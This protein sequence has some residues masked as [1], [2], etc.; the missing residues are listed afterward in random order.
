MKSETTM[1]K[2]EHKEDQGHENRGTGTS[3]ARS[4]NVLHISDGSTKIII[5]ATISVVRASDEKKKAEKCFLGQE[6]GEGRTSDKKAIGL[7]SKQTVQTME[8]STRVGVEDVN[9]CEGMADKSKILF[10]GGQ[11]YKTE[12]DVTDVQQH[13]AMDKTKPCTNLDS[14]V[15]AGTNT[16]ECYTSGVSRDA[17]PVDPVL[18]P[19]EARIQDGRPFDEASGAPVSRGGGEDSAF[20][21]QPPNYSEEISALLAYRAVVP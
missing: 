11:L 2:D 9:N 13:P 15:S 18:V 20:T 14:A 19:E 1:R 12:E 17:Q 7:K 8:R 16:I 4:S 5:T 21:A 6:S 10:N 3:V